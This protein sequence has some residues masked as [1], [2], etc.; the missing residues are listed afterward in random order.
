MYTDLYVDLRFL[1]SLIN[2]QI[3]HTELSFIEYD[4]NVH[5]RL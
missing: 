5:E 1:E 3:L 2:T 4:Y